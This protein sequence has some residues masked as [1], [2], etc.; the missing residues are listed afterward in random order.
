MKDAVIA[1]AAVIVVL[2]GTYVLAETRPNLPPTPSTPFSMTTGEAP[3]IG[4][5]APNEKVV[6]RVNGDPVT[7]REFNDFLEQ[8]PE[9][10]RAFYNSPEGRPMLAQQ[11]I[12]FKALEQEAR[13]LGVASDAEAQTRIKEAAAQIMAAYALQKMIKT[14]SDERVRAEFE[15]EKGQFSSVDLSHILIAFQ[16]AQAPPRPGHPQITLQQAMQKAQ[17]IETKLKGG[18]DFATLA[19]Q[20]SDDA[21]AQAGGRIGEVTPAGLPP[22]VQQSVAALR[23]GQVSAPVRSPYG[24]HIFKAG[25]KQTQS[26]EELKPM[27]IARLQRQDAQDAIARMEKT[28][29]VDYDPKFFP[30]VPQHNAA[31]R[32]KSNG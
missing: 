25:K 32:P 2:A 18:A 28:A 24:I 17:Q 26:Y 6:M 19:K 3:V 1:I 22:E 14:P 21:S 23:E 5:A 16:G 9:Q 13:R 30:T 10:T 29:K 31:P 27:L 4:G 12:K 20:E 11:L 15:K 8:A 7:E